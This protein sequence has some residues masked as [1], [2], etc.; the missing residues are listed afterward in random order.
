M[1]SF[2][3][4]L[5]CLCGDSRERAARKYVETHQLE[6]RNDYTV[7][8]NSRLICEHE[9]FTISFKMNSLLLEGASMSRISG[10][11]RIGQVKKPYIIN[12]LYLF[13][14]FFFLFKV[15]RVKILLVSA[16]CRHCY[17]NV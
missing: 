15:I 11:I 6:K 17:R 2:C 12:F 10:M 4:V 3:F 9:I 13:L 1:E 14:F 5:F 16:D 7:Q 8:I